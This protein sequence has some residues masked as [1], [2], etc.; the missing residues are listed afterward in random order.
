MSTPGGAP[1]DGQDDPAG[2]APAGDSIARNTGFALG[3]SLVSAV[4]TAVLTLFLLRA[5]GPED[6]GVFA[7][8]MSVGALVLIPSNLGI[9]MA[10]SRFV[11]ES[12]RDRGAVHAV[13][14]DALRLKLIVAGAC[15]GVMALLAA[16]IA[17]AY[18]TPEL[19]WPIRIMALAVLGHSILQLW[20]SLFEAERRVSVY[21][22]VIAAESAI[23]TTASIGLVLAGL[24]VSGAMAGRAG[25]YLFAA[26]FGY[27]LLIRT[28]AVRPAVRSGWHGNVRR[29]AG[30][31]S[32]LLIIDGA[33]TL[34][35]RIDVLLIGTIIS[36]EAVGQFEAPLRL[37]ALLS[38]VGTAAASGVAP[39]LARGDE[40]PETGAFVLALRRLMAL[41]GLFIAPMII[42]A[43]P[44]TEIALGTEYSDSAEVLRA[45][46][47]YTF[48]LAISPVLAR[49]V[50]YLGEARLRIPI[51]I[52]ALLLNLVFDLI[53][54]PEIGIVA[55]AI[56]TGIA[57]TFYVAAH[58]WICRR[59]LGIPL[60]PLAAS[61]LRIVASVAVMSAALFAFGTGDVA[62][63][64]L[65]VGGA[66]GSV[67]YVV[68]L[69]GT[70]EVTRP[71]LAA[72]WAQVAAR[73]P[74]R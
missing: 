31:G 66:L 33:F 69:L 23:E 61:F 2:N 14:S 35:S 46:A 39:R 38:Y 56:G 68:A 72:G 41:Q 62:L 7:L 24:G 50:T 5:L 43:E 55:G 64:L 29:I 70:R 65:L 3:V 26:G 11:A 37:I 20:D 17:D 59:L 73:L 12:R 6:Y 18:D 67:V 8:A 19:T 40:Q 9:S 30:Y 45:F 1:G 27:V 28:L 13:I 34:F 63:P 42:W 10:A 15:C 57:Y 48:L 32:A 16:P 25:A 49:G 58:L 74:G 60:M 44:L 4:G 53:F 52:G 54:L 36:I 71:E 47:P 51:A 22:R 21:L